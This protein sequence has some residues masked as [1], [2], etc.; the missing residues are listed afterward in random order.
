M[1]D[2]IA[3]FSTTSPKRTITF[4]VQQPGDVGVF[5][6]VHRQDLERALGESGFAVLYIPVQLV[7]V[8]R[9]RLVLVD[10]IIPSYVDFSVQKG[11]ATRCT[12]YPRDDNSTM[13]VYEF[14]DVPNA[15]RIVEM[16]QAECLVV[17][18]SRFHEA[19]RILEDIQLPDPNVDGDPLD[20][21][22]WVEESLILRR[23]I[24]FFVASRPWFEKRK[25]RY[26]RSYL[27]YGP[28]G[29]G[30]SATIAAIAK[31]IDASIDTFDF[32]RQRQAPDSEFHDWM[33]ATL[34]TSTTNEEI[35]RLLVLED[36]DRYYAKNAA[37][38][39]S[40]S[41]QALL[42]AL[43]G[44]QKRGSSIVVATANH[45]EDLDQQVILRPGR[46]DLRVRFP[47]PSVTEG[48]RF[49]STQLA[50]ESVSY[51]AMREVA[52]MCTGH[53][54]VFLDAIVTTAGSIAF[55]R[56]G[57]QTEDSDLLTAAREHLSPTI[58]SQLRS[59]RSERKTGF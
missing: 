51:D 48:A 22:H 49:L 12:A 19:V 25:R 10:S 50:Q 5:V 40:V 46:F 35:T 3:T 39:P 9:H 13:N 37:V 41:L 32:S 27:L 14:N 34:V 26:T 47:P 24:E 7:R 45:P 57:E 43:D 30:K 52:T 44:P 4:N 20:S 56:Q 1:T 28:P 15:L 6:D 21:I 18:A 11:R 31:K 54:Y 23:D 29:N 53:S 33:T 59:D 8:L 2:T 36:I 38:T 42:N 16:G 17:G 55:A 58:V